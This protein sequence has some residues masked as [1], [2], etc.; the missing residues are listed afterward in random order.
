MKNTTY[1]P[2]SITPRRT[3]DYHF[4]EWQYRYLVIDSRTDSIY[5]WINSNEKLDKLDALYLVLESDELKNLAY[6][7]VYLIEEVF[8]DDRS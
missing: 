4:V 2:Y 3:D 8:I 7:N 6:Y 5:R 1:Q